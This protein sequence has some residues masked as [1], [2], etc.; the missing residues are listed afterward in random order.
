MMG[1]MEEVMEVTMAK[2]M[3]TMKDMPTI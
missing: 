1:V 3:M 2:D